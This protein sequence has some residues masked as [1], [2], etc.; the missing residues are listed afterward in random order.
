MSRH[1]HNR[2]AWDTLNQLSVSIGKPAPTG[3]GRRLGLGLTLRMKCQVGTVINTAV[4]DV[5]AVPRSNIQPMFAKP[6]F[7]IA[8][9][10]RFRAPTLLARIS[11]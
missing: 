8:S 10:A 11:R 6:Q 7:S 1:R 9:R 3:V 2:G 5:V 4:L